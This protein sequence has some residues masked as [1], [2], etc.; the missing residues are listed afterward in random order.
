MDKFIDLLIALVWIA[1][2]WVLYL[3]VAIS[4]MYISQWIN[5][6]WYD[7]KQQTESFVLHGIGITISLIIAIYFYTL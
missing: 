3:A 7:A 6:W 1:L 4:F 2:P 5:N